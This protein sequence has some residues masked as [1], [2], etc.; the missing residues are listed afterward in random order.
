MRDEKG[1]SVPP[2][3]FTLSLCLGTKS[4]DLILKGGLG[5]GKK[6]ALISV[7]NMNHLIIC[8]LE[9]FP[10]CCVPVGSLWLMCLQPFFKQSFS[11]RCLE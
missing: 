2:I 10:S 7:S 6:I 5:S 1:P 8:T 11:S 9:R 3:F 4:I